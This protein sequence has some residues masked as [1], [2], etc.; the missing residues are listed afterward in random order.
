[1]E[2]LGESAALCAR[3][4][5]GAES[6]RGVAQRASGAGRPWPTLGDAAAQTWLPSSLTV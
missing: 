1:M 2:Q 6:V 5:G 4:K 3:D